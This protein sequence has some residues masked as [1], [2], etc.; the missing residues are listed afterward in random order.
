MRTH[1]RLACVAE[2][3]NCEG[4]VSCLAFSLFTQGTFDFGVARFTGSQWWSIRGK[5]YVLIICESA[6]CLQ[7][8]LFSLAQ[9]TT[10]RLTIRALTH[11]YSIDNPKE[12]RRIHP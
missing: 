3:R 2:G 11:T 10:H 4:P 7:D 6:Y 12:V 1:C 5:I 8:S 9:T